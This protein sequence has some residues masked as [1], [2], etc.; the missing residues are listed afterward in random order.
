[1]VERAAVG[2]LIYGV[3]KSFLVNTSS[4]RSSFEEYIGLHASSAS[5]KKMTSVLEALKSAEALGM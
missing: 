4:S 2:T 3:R 5:A 1:M